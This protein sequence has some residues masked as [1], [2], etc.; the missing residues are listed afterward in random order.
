MQAV[1]DALSEL[2]RWIQELA[3][4]AFTVVVDGAEGLLQAAAK[5]LV[6]SIVSIVK[7]KP[8]LDA[9]LFGLPV[10]GAAIR[11]GREAGIEFATFRISNFGRSR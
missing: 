2:L 6:E 11:R 3:I 8:S 4:K 7:A 1:A 10:L 9:I 5:E